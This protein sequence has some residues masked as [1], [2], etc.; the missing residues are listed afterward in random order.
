MKILL[1]G[2]G[3]I[4]RR[5]ARNLRL[6]VPDAELVVWDPPLGAGS[7]FGDVAALLAAHRDAAGAIIASPAEYHR[8]QMDQL[9]AAGIPF[10]VEKPVV[11]VDQRPFTWPTFSTGHPPSHRCAVGHQYRF[12][13]VVEQ[14]R[15]AWRAL[16]H[17]RFEASDDLAG[18]YGP[19]CPATM[20][21]HAV[22]LALY[23][24]GPAVMVDLHT[25]CGLTLRGSILHAH[26]RSE[27][28]LKMAAGPRVSRVVATD[29]GERRLE[30]ALG[31]DD[32][33][34][35]EA[36]RAWLRYREAGLLDGRL[37]TVPDGLAV[38]DVLAQV[39]P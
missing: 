7:Q 14:Q 26:G 25:D 1:F 36:L 10:Y 29:D 34:Y 39:Q 11:T 12:H 22:D 16:G 23:V 37:C 3:S 9:L 8:E 19:T 2:F 20:G 32:S 27:Y 6:L 24:L 31:P 35:L 4:G 33:M 21:S 18:R 17:L 15:H 38:V 30:H 28:D 5:H 13:P